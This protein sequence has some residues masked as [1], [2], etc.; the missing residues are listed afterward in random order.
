MAVNGNGGVEFEAV[1]NGRFVIDGALVATSGGLDGDEAETDISHVADET[2]FG[3][4][5][6][7]LSL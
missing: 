7:A 1:G 3:P 6:Q 4:A 2:N 5:R